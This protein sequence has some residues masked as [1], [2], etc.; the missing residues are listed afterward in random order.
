MY[1]LRYIEELEG[2]SYTIAVSESVELLKDRASEYLKKMADLIKHWSK[3]KI[4]WE[5]YRDDTYT[6]Y[7]NNSEDIFI[8]QTV[9]FLEK[10]KL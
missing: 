6:G 3:K 9:E 5:S 8:I 4:E 1:V 10:V 2:Y 7:I